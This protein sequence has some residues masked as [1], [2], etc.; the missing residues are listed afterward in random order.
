MSRLIKW[1]GRNKRD[2]TG[3]KKTAGILKKKK[4]SR[5]G[6]IFNLRDIFKMFQPK[7]I[8]LGGIIFSTYKK[9]ETRLVRVLL[10]FLFFKVKMNTNKSRL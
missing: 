8:T 4:R 3:F 7:I 5:C 2:L 9:K 10:R 1:C 6:A